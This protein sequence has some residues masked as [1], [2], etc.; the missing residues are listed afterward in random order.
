MRS[1]VRLKKLRTKQ[2]VLDYVDGMELRTLSDVVDLSMN[3]LP[4]EAVV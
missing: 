2:D 4:G 1:D 3:V